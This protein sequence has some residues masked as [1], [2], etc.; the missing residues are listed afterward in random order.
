M[1]N[2]WV[3][4]VS[5]LPRSGTSLMMQ[6]L[7]AGGIPPLTDGIRA[8]D[9][10][11]PAGYFELERIQQLQSDSA[12]LAEARGHAVKIVS[13]L[14]YD[15][16]P[17]LPCRIILMR[18]N[19]D[20]ILASQQAMLRR[21]GQAGLG[22]PDDQM[23]RHFETHL[24]KIRRWIAERNIPCLE[25]DYNRLLQDPEPSLA[26]LVAFLGGGIQPGALRQ[27]IRPELY[28]NLAT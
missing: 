25:C 21:R 26:E 12:W 20:E 13:L 11:N 10:D 24:A 14:L 4:V 6:M 2:N 15:L 18:R 23:R 19:L 8:A 7:A 16:P 17:A 9:V 5:G 3:T 28:R 27:A 22:P 1:S